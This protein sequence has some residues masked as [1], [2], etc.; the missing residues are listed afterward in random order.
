MHRSGP[1][2]SD[3][4]ELGVEAAHQVSTTA[5]EEEVFH[6][7]VAAWGRDCQFSLVLRIEA[8]VPHF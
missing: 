3:A 6:R 7:E 2:S 4:W 8:R 1:P 5:G